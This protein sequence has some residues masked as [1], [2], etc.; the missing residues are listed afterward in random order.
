MSEN[1]K[2]LVIAGIPKNKKV[3]KFDGDDKWY[4]VASVVQELDFMKLGITAKAEVEVTFSDNDE[5]IFIKVLGKKKNY[6]KKTSNKETSSN[7]NEDKKV[8]HIST[9]TEDKKVVKFEEESNWYELAENVR[10]LDLTKYGVITGAKVNVTFKE[11]KVTFLQVVKEE[12]KS[13]STSTT[14]KS[15][16]Y[17]N[18]P[19]RQTSIEIQACIKS[20]N[21]IAQGVAQRTEISLDKLKTLI[22]EIAEHNYELLKKLK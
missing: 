12:I 22:T 7:T 10:K 19:D 15:T 20:A 17:Y 6:T 4:D 9:I 11:G 8:L 2:T 18:D 1:K 16:S 14:S 3:I 5:I 13:N 21:I